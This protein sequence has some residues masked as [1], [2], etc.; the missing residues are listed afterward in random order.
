M[1]FINISSKKLYKI[2]LENQTLQIFEKKNEICMS[3]A[4]HEYKKK[5]TAK[6]LN[7]SNLL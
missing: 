3:T 4:R 5:K 1:N 7:V 6:Y 2:L